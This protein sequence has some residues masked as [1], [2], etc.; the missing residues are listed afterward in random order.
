M[1]NEI[2]APPQ[3]FVEG[4]QAAPHPLNAAL[5][6]LHAHKS[7]VDRGRLI[8]PVV[9]RAVG[10]LATR[11]LAVGIEGQLVMSHRRLLAVRALWLD[12]PMRNG[13]SGRRKHGRAAGHRNNDREKNRHAFHCAEAFGGD[14]LC[15]VRRE[16]AADF[17]KLYQNTCSPSAISASGESRMISERAFFA[18]RISTSD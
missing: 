13:L 4:T 17:A 9:R 12:G 7:V 14:V 18:P 11:G 1:A 16:Q 15:F 10:R 5:P 6:P 8:E 2:D 3:N